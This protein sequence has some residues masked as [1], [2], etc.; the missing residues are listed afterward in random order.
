M[1]SSRSVTFDASASAS[2]TPVPTEEV[3]AAFGFKTVKKVDVTVGPVTG[4]DLT[5]EGFRKYL[6]DRTVSKACFGYLKDMNNRFVMGAAR[7]G[8]MK[9]HFVGTR[10][11]N[12]KVDPG[13]VSAVLKASG[14]IT[15]QTSDDDS[16]TITQEMYVGYK[17]F[18]FRDLGV[19]QLEA[20]DGI[21]LE[22]GKFRLE[23]VPVQMGTMH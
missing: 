13:K 14:G 4:N 8:S 19:P 16:F 21:K 20:A 3:G 9:Y 5:I 1:S 2:Y 23:P 7:T 15:E 6:E 17:A 22:A 12:A 18:V 10:D 11:V